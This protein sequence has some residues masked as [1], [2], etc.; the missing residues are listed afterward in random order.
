ML[1]CT[2]CT[3]AQLFIRFGLHGRSAVQHH[4]Q[5]LILLGCDAL[6]PSHEDPHSARAVEVGG[7]LDPRDGRHPG[8]QRRHVRPPLTKQQ[9]GA[10]CLEAC[11]HGGKPIPWKQVQKTDRKIHQTKSAEISQD[12]AC[13]PNLEP[14]PL[15]PPI[16]RVRKNSPFFFSIFGG[17]QG[18]LVSAMRRN[19]RSRSEEAQDGNFASSSPVAPAYIAP[20]RLCAPG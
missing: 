5:H 12:S 20:R 17:S 10:S 18:V 9:H 14:F 7:L 6:D 2:T 8:H 1:S 13:G 15:N 4:K 11:V 3:P 19:G 16:K